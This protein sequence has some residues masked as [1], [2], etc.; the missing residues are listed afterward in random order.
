ML[1]TA[2]IEAM[3]GVSLGFMALVVSS[4]STSNTPVVSR[5]SNLRATFCW[6]RGSPSWLRAKNADRRAPTRTTYGFSAATRLV[7]RATPTSEEARPRRLATTGPC[8]NQAVA[9]GA[10]RALA[11]TQCLSCNARSV[12]SRGFGTRHRCNRCGFY[13]ADRSARRKSLG[14]FRHHRHSTRTA[15]VR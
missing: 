4:G 3:S 7:V 10:R 15:C 2:A 5:K 9:A 6:R 11:A 12:T 8:Q 14:R 1:N 13:P